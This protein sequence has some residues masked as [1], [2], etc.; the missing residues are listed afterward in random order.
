MLNLSWENLIRLIVCG[1]ASVKKYFVEWET[2]WGHTLFWM[3]LND[4]YVC[5]TFKIIF[6][7]RW[8]WITL[9]VDVY[10]ILFSHYIHTFYAYNNGN[11]YYLCLCGLMLM[12]RKRLCVTYGWQVLILSHFPN[13]KYNDTFKTVKNQFSCDYFRTWKPPSRKCRPYAS[14]VFRV[15]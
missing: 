3:S 9:G 4:V 10:F 7:S 8:I 14:I 13:S 11:Y 2:I 12:T 15:T 1:F 5:A 6:F